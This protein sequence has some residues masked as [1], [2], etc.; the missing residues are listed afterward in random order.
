MGLLRRVGRYSVRMKNGHHA[1]NRS[2]ADGNP[3]GGCVGG[4]GFGICWQDGPLGRD[5][6]RVKP[7]G[8]F[9]EDVLEACKQ[10]LDYFQGSKFACFENSLAIHHIELALGALD[11]RTRD[12]EERK[13]EGTHEV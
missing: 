13:V 2:D 12:R 3:T 4:Q 9:V 8:A 7:N 10:R 11:D 6:D 5:G 1:S